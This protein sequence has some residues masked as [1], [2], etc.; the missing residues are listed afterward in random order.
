MKKLIKLS[1]IALFLGIHPVSCDRYDD[2]CGDLSNY[3]K[4]VLITEINYN[5]FNIEPL[6][7][8]LYRVNGVTE[9]DTYY[10][11]DS[12]GI[13][14]S[15]GMTHRIAAKKNFNFGF[16]QTANACYP[17][18]P[19]VHNY[20]TKVDIIFT[21]SPTFFN[22]SIGTI[23]KGD[24]LSNLFGA[25]SRDT[26]YSTPSPLHNQESWDSWETT[27]IKLVKYN[28]DSL[29]LSVDALFHMAD[30]DDLYINDISINLLPTDK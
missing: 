22:D 25:F 2:D 6:E 13:G 27:F 9:N 1:L 4:L 11:P 26:Y 10:H 12:V 19:D 23:N 17:S 20:I 15:I 18:P 16:A 29:S 8:E 5:F 21:G 3:P 24:T 28:R 7:Q 14:F 30:G